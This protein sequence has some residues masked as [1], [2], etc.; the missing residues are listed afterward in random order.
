[1]LQLKSNYVNSSSPFAV[2]NFSNLIFSYLKDEFSNNSEIIVLC[3]G[4]DRS[5]GDALGP[6]VG[7]KLYPTLNRYG[8]VHLFGT[9][10]SPV[11]AKNLERVIHNLE[12]DYKDPFIIAVDASLGRHERVGYLSIKNTPLKPGAGVNKLLPAVG[13]ISITGVVNIGGMMEY[14]VLQNT[15]LSMVM[16]MASIISKSINSALLKFYSEK[17]KECMY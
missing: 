17:D 8:N 2:M 1:M 3:I 7:T 11:H 5:T 14:M 12:T 15:R 16:N 4:T 10:E 6:L 13:D 9:L